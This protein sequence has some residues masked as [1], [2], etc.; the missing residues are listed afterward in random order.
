MSERLPDPNPIV[1]M[2]LGIA[3]QPVGVKPNRARERR[4]QECV[5]LF[6]EPCRH[7]D[8]YAVEGENPDLVAGREV[9]RSDGEDGGNHLPKNPTAGLLNKD[10][11]QTHGG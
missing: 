1:E 10:F 4:N 3:G 9:E 7:E 2:K 6:A 5:A 8:R 11:R